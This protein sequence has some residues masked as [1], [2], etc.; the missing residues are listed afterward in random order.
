MVLGAK[1]VPAGFRAAAEVAKCHR[2][3]SSTYTAATLWSR[4]GSPCERLTLLTRRRADGK[5]KRKRE[6]SKE[7][8]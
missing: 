8:Y 2:T 1:I 7:T 3:E 6:P 4:K 5:K